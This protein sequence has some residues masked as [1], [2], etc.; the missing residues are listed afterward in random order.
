[1]EKFTAGLAADPLFAQFCVREKKDKMADG[2]GCT[3][4]TYANITKF[5]LPSI[6]PAK[7]E[8]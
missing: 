6:D 5:I 3:Q 8:T 1:M 4:G 7:N 2:N